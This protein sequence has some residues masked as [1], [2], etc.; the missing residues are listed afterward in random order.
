MERNDYMVTVV[1]NKSLYEE[2]MQKARRIG[3]AAEL[4]AAEA[5]AN[6][7]ISPAISQLIRDEEIHRL[8]LPKEFGHPQ[9]DWRTFKIGRAHV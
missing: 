5:D 8:I 3:Q 4:E 9:L 7:T 1:E 6:S 2:M